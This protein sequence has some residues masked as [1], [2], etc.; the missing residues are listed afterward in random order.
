MR[1]WLVAS[2]H[3]DRRATVDDREAGMRYWFVRTEFLLRE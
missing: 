2:D 3:F 1:V